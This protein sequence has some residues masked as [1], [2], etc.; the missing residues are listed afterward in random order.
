MR[1]VKIVDEHNH[2]YEEGS[3]DNYFLQDT[4]LEW[5]FDKGPLYKTIYDPCEVRVSHRMIRK[6]PDNFANKIKRVIGKSNKDIEELPMVTTTTTYNEEL[7]ESM[8]RR[9]IRLSSA[10]RECVDLCERCQNALAHTYLGPE[11]GYAYNSTEFIFSNCRCP[12]CQDMIP[13]FDI[14]NGRDEA[15]LRNYIK[16]TAE[17]VKANENIK[18]DEN[19]QIELMKYY[20]DKIY[21]SC[22]HTGNI[23][24]EILREGDDLVVKYNISVCITDTGTVKG[25]DKEACHGEA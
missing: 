9:G 1:V 11:H 12:N 16:T 20:L 22:M 25:T 7:V 8:V 10:I 19:K 3:M 21:V 18:D 13:S 5:D 24:Y 14:C 2:R 15:A 6:I 17:I 4:S 23:P